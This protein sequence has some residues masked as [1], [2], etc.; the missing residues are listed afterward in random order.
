MKEKEAEMQK[1]L[2]PSKTMGGK[3]LNFDPSNDLMK[4]A[5]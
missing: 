1:I 2:N 3:I 5:D 4:P